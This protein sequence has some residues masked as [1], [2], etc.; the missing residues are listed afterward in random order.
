[1]TK[2]IITSRVVT[3]FHSIFKC[4][5][6]IFRGIA[7]DVIRKTGRITEGKSLD[8]KSLFFQLNYFTSISSMYDCNLPFLS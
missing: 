6:L 8:E 5:S 1:M 2:L 3:G 4:H 7:E